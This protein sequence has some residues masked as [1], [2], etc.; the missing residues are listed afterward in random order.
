M[1][2]ELEGSYM[3]STGLMVMKC[4]HLGSTRKEGKHAGNVVTG[5]ERK[6]DE[7]EA[8]GGIELMLFGGIEPE[9]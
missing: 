6:N 3:R 8:A 1:L 5:K 4:S 7:R 9:L 2:N